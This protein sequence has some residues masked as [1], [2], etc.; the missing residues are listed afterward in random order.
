MTTKNQLQKAYDKGFAD[1]GEEKI[2]NA[3]AVLLCLGTLFCG[4]GVGLILTEAGSGCV[5]TPALDAVCEELYDESYVFKDKS[6][7]TSEFICIKEYV[8]VPKVI[9]ATSSCNE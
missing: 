5:T 1:G 8:T 6:L 4:I 7:S 3:I 2:P 9:T